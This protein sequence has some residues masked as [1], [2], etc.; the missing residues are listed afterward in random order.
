MIDEARTEELQAEIARALSAIDR[1]WCVLNAEREED[2]SYTYRSSR[3]TANHIKQCLVQ[4]SETLDFEV[5][6]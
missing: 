1:V 3:K 4:L 5:S 2:G 6:T